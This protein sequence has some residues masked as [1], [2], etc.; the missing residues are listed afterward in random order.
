[1][2]LFK[3]TSKEYSLEQLQELIR[4]GK[5]AEELSVGDQLTVTFDGKEMLYDII[6]IDV[7]KLVNP[8]LKHSITIQAHTLFEERA[9]NNTDKGS[10]TNIWETSDIRAYLNS[11]E[12]AARFTGLIPY[13]QKVYKENADRNPTEETF[14]LLSLDEYKE[15]KTPYPFYKGGEINR[16]KADENGETDWHWTRSAFRG[17]ACSAW[18]V[19]AGGYASNYNARYALRFAPACV[20]G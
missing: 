20:I 18:S 4:S 15:D 5:A 8:D 13:L 7:E 11:E 2:K 10:E 6:G 19:G 14:F 17:Y 16:V 9:F 12:Y 1:M 3:K